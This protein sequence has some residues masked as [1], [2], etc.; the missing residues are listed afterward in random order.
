MMTLDEFSKWHDKHKDDPEIIG[1]CPLCKKPIDG[2]D[3]HPDE[4][5]PWKHDG[6]MVHE[7]CYYYGLSTL[8][9]Q[10]PIRSPRPH[11]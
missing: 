10:N 8:I 4:D 2:R 9:E 7:D 3:V 5:W 11:G 1:E 6:K